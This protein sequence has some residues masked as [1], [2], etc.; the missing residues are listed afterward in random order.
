MCLFAFFTLLLCFV[1]LLSTHHLNWAILSE[2]PIQPN[3]TLPDAVPSS[4]MATCDTRKELIGL[5]CHLII[6]CCCTQQLPQ[7]DYSYCASR[8]GHPAMKRNTEPAY[9][10]LLP[11]KVA[12]LLA[13]LP[14]E[15]KKPL[16]VSAV[17]EKHV[18]FAQW[19]R[20]R[21]LTSCG[22]A[23][24]LLPLHLYLCGCAVSELVAYSRPGLASPSIQLREH[25]AHVDAYQGTMMWARA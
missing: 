2:R 18:A 10:C 20:A 25:L 17:R 13:L 12:R 5:P 14:T 9:I 21:A 23:V 4:G 24:P 3:C 6:S 15:A 19:H 11:A 7:A 8:L 22:A 1:D 16:P